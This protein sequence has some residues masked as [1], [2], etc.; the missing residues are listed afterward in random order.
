MMESAM[1]SANI[2]APLDDTII[3]LTNTISSA[4][5]YFRV[6]TP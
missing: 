4:E 6:R 1:A 5:R 2:P 3:T